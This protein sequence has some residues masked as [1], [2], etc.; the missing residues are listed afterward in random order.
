VH[1]HMRAYIPLNKE[2][3]CSL[4]QSCASFK[5]PCGTG[6]SKETG[7]RGT[8]ETIGRSDCTH[9]CKIVRNIRLSCLF[10]DCSPNW[11]Y[12]QIPTLHA[13]ASACS[14]L[15]FHVCGP[16]VFRL[17]CIL[18]RH[19]LRTC[20]KQLWPSEIILISCSMF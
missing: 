14:V 1:V 20:V 6:S 15:C 11:F 16:P 13:C 18:P 10:V 5:V 9:C 19:L 2:M 12:I 17:Y 7:R 4:I 3:F 8:Q